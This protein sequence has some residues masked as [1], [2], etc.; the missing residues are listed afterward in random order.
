MIYSPELEGHR[1]IYCANLIHYFIHKG[2]KVFLVTAGFYRGSWTEV[3]NN[4]YLCEYFNSRNVQIV[5]LVHFYDKEVL[6]NQMQ[7]VVDLQI[8][9]DIELT[10]FAFADQLWVELANLILP[11]SRKLRGK[12]YGIFFLLSNF[13]Y[14][15]IN[16]YSEKSL[17]RQGLK[18][19]R[20]QIDYIKSRVSKVHKILFTNVI[21]KYF[22]VLD[23]SLFLDEYFVTKMNCER[24]H[25]L[26]DMSKSLQNI[27][28]LSSSKNFI[29]FKRDYSEFLEL[30]KNKDIIL[31]FGIESDRHGVNYLLRLVD[32]HPDLVYVHL[33]ETTG[34]IKNRKEFNALKNRLIQQ[35]RVFEIDRWV[36]D[37]MIIDLFFESIKYL[38]L[39]YKNHYGSSGMMLEALSYGKPVL[40]PNIGLMSRRVVDNQ[41]G[42]TFKH[43]SYS[44]F[45]DEF[46][47]LRTEYHI[48]HKRTEEYYHHEFSKDRIIEALDKIWI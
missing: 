34:K 36:D 21:L 2:C 33:G 5:N 29:V 12:N 45:C 31:C 47:I 35:G 6:R 46:H 9:Y 18:G 38:L 15:E 41:L 10:L 16:D 28:G 44:S 17:F 20:S 19:L 14:K 43:L 4:P 39:P 13:I 30:H 22:R 11:W 8:K 40:V 27:R 7:V 37:Q 32:Q 42:R 25:Y 3:A 26:P 1:Q 24:F 23:G 48:Y